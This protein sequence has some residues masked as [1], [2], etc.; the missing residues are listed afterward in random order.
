MRTLI[1]ALLLTAAC[2]E[3]KCTAPLVETL[4]GVC[5]V[6]GGEAG[7]GEAGHNAEPFVIVERD[8]GQRA[9]LDQDG[10]KID[11]Q[12]IDKPV[13]GSGGGGGIAGSLV[14]AVS[15]SGGAGLPGESK[16]DHGHGGGVSG[17]SV[18]GGA[19]GSVGAISLAGSYSP[20]PICGNGI[21]EAD[22]ACDGDCPSCDDGDPCTSDTMTG[23]KTSCDVKC[24]HKAITAAITGD[25]CCPKEAR[26]S[27]DGDCVCRG[28][29]DCGGDEYCSSDHRCHLLA[30]SGDGDCADDRYCT[31]TGHCDLRRSGL[32]TRDRNCPTGQVCK[33]SD[34]GFNECQ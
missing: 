15:G 9:D 19:G 31:S 7:K 33:A 6:P 13:G 4:P 28:D 3:P 11:G 25:K 27:A 1:L 12:Q 5:H 17:A 20:S 26:A 23:S 32:C 16:F 18:V 2:G 21:T 24:E 29:N 14:G 8:A 22:E 10:G 34:I 30:C